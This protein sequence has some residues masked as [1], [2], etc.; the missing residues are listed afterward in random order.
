MSRMKSRGKFNAQKYFV[1]QVKGFG[2]NPADASIIYRYTRAVVAHAWSRKGKAPVVPGRFS[3]LYSAIMKLAKTCVA[4][5]IRDLSRASER[6]LK[7]MFRT[8]PRILPPRRPS[9][10]RVLVPKKVPKRIVHKYSFKM[11]K[12]TYTIQTSKKLKS[13]RLSYLHTGYARQIFDLLKNRTKTAKG[14]PVINAVVINRKRY[15]ST[16]AT[17]RQFRRQYM[18]FF[19][20]TLADPKKRIKVKKV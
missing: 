15:D 8:M 18:K 14:K 12:K 6:K 3:Y 17:F 2:F 1:D 19:P 7:T 11:G 5:N 20:T 10:I 9:K 4:N 16:T 13:G